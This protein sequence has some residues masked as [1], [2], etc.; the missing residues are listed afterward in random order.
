[1]VVMDRAYANKDDS[2]YSLAFKMTAS[3]NIDLHYIHS[4]TKIYTLKIGAEP[5]QVTFTVK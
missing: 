3:S 1:M 4:E 5:F 2:K